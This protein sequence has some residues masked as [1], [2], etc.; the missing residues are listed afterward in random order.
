M[1]LMPGYKHSDVGVIPDEWDAKPLGDIGNSLIGLTYRPSEVRKYGTLVLRSSNVQNGTL[2]FD[3]NV[4]VEADIPERI[5][6]KPGDI[7]VCV[8]NGSRD[9]IGKAALIDER[10]IG[11]TFGAFMGVFRSDHGQLLHHVFQS[12]IFKKQINEHL[13]ATINQITNRSLNSFKVPLPPTNEERTRIART[14]SD[15]DALLATLDEVI[16]KKR[17]LKQAT[18]HQLL[19][20]ETRLP[21]FSGNWDVKQLGSIGH[22]WK[23]RGVKKDEAHSGTLPCIRYGEI[24]THHN[25]YIKSFNSWISP[26]V[27]ATAT[28]LKQ[29]DLLFAGSGETKEEIGKCVAFVD[30]CEAYA[31]GDT[32]ILRATGINPMF[33]G[34][35]CNTAPIA[36]QKASKGQGDA[37]VHISAAALSSIVLALPSLPEQNAIATALSDMDAELSVLEARR[38]KTRN[39]KQAMMQE[40]LTGKTR[41]IAK[42]GSHV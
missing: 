1:E 4:F 22:F 17:D 2:C 25:D 16:T 30:D 41:L 29:G 15:V 11:M 9:L 23:G 36:V 33:M 19:T 14:L 39:I 5:M 38:E 10:A 27:A 32:V 20:G 12:G 24:Y 26:Q 13:G 42:E 6:V 40:L 18:M 8:R 37:V 31:G 7:L 3:D 21:G 35:Y 34:Y 28:R